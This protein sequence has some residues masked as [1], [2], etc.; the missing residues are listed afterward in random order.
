MCNLFSG[1]SGVG[2]SVFPFS[3]APG[4]GK[5]RWSGASWNGFDTEDSRLRSSGF[6]AAEGAP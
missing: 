4:L 1:D 5:A 6:Q 3:A 2:N